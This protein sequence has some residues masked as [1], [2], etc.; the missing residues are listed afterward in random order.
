MDIFLLSSYSPPH[1]PDNFQ[2]AVG[3]KRYRKFSFKRKL[4]FHIMLVCF[5]CGYANDFE[6][7][8]FSL[9]QPSNVLF[10]LITKHKRIAGRFP[11]YCR[12]PARWFLQAWQSHNPSV[13]TASRFR[14]VPATDV[15]CSKVSCFNFAFQI[16]YPIKYSS[17]WKMA[18]PGCRLYFRN[19]LLPAK[20]LLKW[21]T[22]IGIP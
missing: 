10:Q 18:N 13:P 4:Y 22:Y 6:L 16:K 21:S 7:R 14:S 8:W 17:I 19:R 12:T 11:G 5:L 1:L 20:A 9:L 15:L 2:G 3:Q